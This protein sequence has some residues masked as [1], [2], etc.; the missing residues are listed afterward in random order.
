MSRVGFAGVLTTAWVLTAVAAAAGSAVR[1][2]PPPIGSP[3]GGAL[4]LEDC[5]EAVLVDPQ[6]H[7]GRFGVAPYALDPEQAERLWDVS[8]RLLGR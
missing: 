7:T 6:T 1:A 4:A 2:Q 3:C 8:L 5:N